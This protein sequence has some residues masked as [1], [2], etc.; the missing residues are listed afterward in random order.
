M[1]NLWL[2][3]LEGIRFYLR[4]VPKGWW[5]R[6]PFLPLYSKKYVEFRRHT[7]YGMK[8]HGWG[9]PPPREQLEDGRRFL[10]WRRKFRLENGERRSR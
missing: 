5:K 9:R 10:L 6:W 4:I 3:L 7:A 2:A 8:E 1:K